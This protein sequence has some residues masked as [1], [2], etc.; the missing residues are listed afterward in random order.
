MKQKGIHHVFT[1]PTECIICKGV[2][3]EFALESKDYFL[4]Q[5]I[6]KLY[7]CKSCGLMFT[8]PQPGITAIMEYYNSNEYTAHNT[9]SHT[10][11]NFLY[12]YARNIALKAKLRMIRK[13]FKTGKLLDFGSGTGEFLNH[14]HKSGWDVMGIE[15]NSL[16]RERSIQK[17]HLNIGN[18]DDFDNIHVKSFDVITL[19]HVMEHHNDPVKLMMTNHKLL[20][21]GGLLVIALPNYE[22]WDADFYGKFWAAYDVPR[23]LYHFSQTAVSLL[24]EKSGF[25]IHEIRPLYFD[26]YYI[27]LL[28]EKYKRGKTNYFR[29]MVNGFRS[30][31]NAIRGNSGFSSW[32]YLMTKQ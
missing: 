24:V 31:F 25:K 29:A 5:Q 4:S 23:H 2:E 15:P 1:P 6:F 10:L 17:Y 12:K 18:S 22:S 30:N 19:W 32:V 9:D 21:T 27:S 20:K 11:K 8:R 14:C 16:A 13:Y 7:R 3:F 28:S 26:S